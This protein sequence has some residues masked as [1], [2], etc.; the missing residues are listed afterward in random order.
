MAVVLF[1]EVRQKAIVGNT[2]TVVVVAVVVLYCVVHLGVRHTDC[3]G[4][5]EVIQNEV[6]DT[7]FSENLCLISLLDVRF[8]YYIAYQR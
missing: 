8:F 1:E 2:W 5:S 3:F 4:I 6:N 7:L